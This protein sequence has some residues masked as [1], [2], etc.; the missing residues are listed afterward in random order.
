M[1]HDLPN[2]TFSMRFNPISSPSENKI[3]ATRPLEL[4]GFIEVNFE[5]EMGVR[6]DGE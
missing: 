6:A 1:V 3:S 2:R 5:K 4:V